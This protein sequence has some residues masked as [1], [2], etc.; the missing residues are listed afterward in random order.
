VF[1]KLTFLMLSALILTYCATLVLYIPQ[2]WQPIYWLGVISQLMTVALSITVAFYFIRLTDRSIT[3]QE[4][5]MP[6]SQLKIDQ[7]FV[8]DLMTDASDAIILTIAEFEALLA[9]PVEM[10]QI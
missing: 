3:D 7:S 4:L 6:L 2:L 1:K 9:L 8:R 5:R 10:T